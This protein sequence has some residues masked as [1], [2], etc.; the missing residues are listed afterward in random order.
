VEKINS[1]FCVKFFRKISEE[2]KKK[3]KRKK[4]KRQK[5]S[6]ISLFRRVFREAVLIESNALESLPTSGTS[7]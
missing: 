6:E 3:E 7:F 2:K 1:S 4:Q 5:N